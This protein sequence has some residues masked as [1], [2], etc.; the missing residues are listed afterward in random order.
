MASGLVSL[1]PDPC[2]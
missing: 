1:I 2:Y